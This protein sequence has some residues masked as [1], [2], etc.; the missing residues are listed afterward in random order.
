MSHPAS[1]T[2]VFSFFRYR[3][4][5]AK[6][7]AFGMMQFAARSLKRTPGL[8][9]FKLLGSGRGDGFHPMADFGVYGLMSVWEKE[10]AADRFLQQS[11]LM[12]RYQRK[13]SEDWH[14]FLQPLEIRGAWDG[15]NPFGSSQSEDTS[16]PVAVLTRATIRTGRLLRFWRE[17]PP[18]SQALEQQP[19]MIC[20]F[21]IGEWPLVQM[22]TFSLWEGETAMREFAYRSRYHRQAIA[23]TKKIGWFSE[24]MYARFR[25]YRSEGTWGGSDPLQDY[26]L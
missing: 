11:R 5:L 18:V 6:L 26:L 23:N 21:G 13:A 24:E 12:R 7:W 1:P 10:A 8:H 2:V 15:H 19:G 16:G 17:V 22:A 25:P 4:F 20:K 3:H 14:I 9:F